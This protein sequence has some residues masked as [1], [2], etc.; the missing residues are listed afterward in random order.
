[1]FPCQKELHFLSNKH[2]KI[3][4]VVNYSPCY[5]ELDC[6]SVFLLKTPLAKIMELHFVSKVRYKSKIM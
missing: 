3:K 4:F 1:M 2:P 6:S 5:V